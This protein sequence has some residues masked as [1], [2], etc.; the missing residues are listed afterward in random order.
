MDKGPF[1]FAA[2]GR[3]PAGWTVSRF[4]CACRVSPAHYSRGSRPSSAALHYV[5]LKERLLM[6][7]TKI[8]HLSF[9]KWWGKEGFVP[10][11]CGRPLSCG[12][13]GEPL[14]LR[15]AA[16]LLLDTPILK[17]GVINEQAHPYV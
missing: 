13:D 15:C 11:R 3:F 7:V 10:F 17:G 4:S 5:L 2:V 16:P 9:D 1:L 12:V 6:Y 14:Q 8:N